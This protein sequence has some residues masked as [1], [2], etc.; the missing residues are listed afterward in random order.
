MKALPATRS[1]LAC[2]LFI[3]LSLL[4]SPAL[5]AEY[6]PEDE[7]RFASGLV[8]LGMADYAQ[9][10][11]DEVVRKNPDMKT[12]AAAVQ[13]KILV[14]LRK[15]D[16]AQRVVNAIPKSDPNR[17][18]VALGFANVLYAVG[19]VEKAKAIY[20]AYFKAQR[21]QPKDKDAL[22]FYR[23]AAYAFSQIQGEAGDYKGAVEALGHILD[24]KPAPA[25]RRRVLSEQAALC[26]KAARK[27]GGQDRKKYLDILYKNVK[28]LRWGGVDLWHGQAI[29]HQAYALLIEGKEKEAEETLRD[30]LDIMN[31]IDR[32][33]A[34]SNFPRRESP[35]AVARY[36]LGTLYEKKGEQLVKSGKTKK[37]GLEELKAA[38]NHYFN[39]YLKYPN[40]DVGPKCGEKVNQLKKEI[41]ELIGKEIDIPK[42]D[43]SEVAASHFK[44]ADG[45]FRE[46]DYERAAKKYLELLNQFPE[47]KPSVQALGSLM[48]SYAN[49]DSPL[50]VKAVAGYTAE[51]FA[52]VE[53]AA[54][55]LL[56]VAKHYY[57]AKQEDMY[58]QISEYYVEHFPKHEHAGMILFTLGEQLWKAKDYAAAEQYYVRI[59]DNY[60][61]DKYFP[62]ALNRV[63]WGYYLREDYTNALT[64]FSALLEATT[65][66]LEKARGKLY[67]A[68]CHR[69]LSQYEEALKEYGALEQWLTEKDTPYLPSAADKEEGENLLSV[70]MFFAGHCYS[71]MNEPKDA[72]PGYR[73]KAIEAYRKMVERF[74]KS[75]LAPRALSRLGAVYM[76]LDKSDEAVQVFR[77]LEKDYPDSAAGKDA[78]FTMV[79][80]LVETKKFDKASAKCEEMFNDPDRY[81]PEQFA[82]I[83]Q[84]MLDNGQFDLA[85]KAFEQ[86]KKTADERK[87]IERALYGLGKAYTQLGKPEQSIK[88][89]EDLLLRYEKS[90]LYFEAK[91]LLGEAYMKENKLKEALDALRDVFLRGTES[92]LMMRATIALSE[93][94]DKQ[95][96]KTEALAAHTRITYLA[97]AGD[98]RMRAKVAESNMRVIRLAMEMG[99]WDEAIKAADQYLKTFPGGEKVNEVRQLKA[100]I[101]M[102]MMQSGSATPDQGGATE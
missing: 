37:K 97:D 28:E 33:L 31:E 69:Q 79:E 91:L 87:H 10:V 78:L 51:R 50:Y 20:D 99:L 38:L 70:A 56:R 35:M 36:L 46:K 42:V 82:R 44:Q 9:K 40:S 21:R 13:V 29:T 53:E 62:K 7:V 85:A 71:M 59:K 24:S 96:N 101:R 90:G 25:I 75:E 92:D 102:K 57:D 54:S 100:E 2:C 49:L 17:A 45:F 18:E 65:P 16:E 86:V 76:E 47:T 67:A 73:Q 32:F 83:G 80:A 6:K 55:A 88:N 64:W 58:R 43:M 77:Q 84:L 61:Q 30:N 1:T 63:G 23:D 98:P 81:K 4:S 48:L 94:Y 93:L 52:G 60:K 12:K 8:E 3:C 68:H 5:C 74:P 27:A 39:V 41:E 72:V 26:L 14:A 15:L 95:N 11:L 66:S 34:E 19:E 22:E 89:L